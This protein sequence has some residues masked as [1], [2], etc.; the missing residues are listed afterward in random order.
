[1]LEARDRPASTVTRMI[2]RLL[3][4]DVDGIL[5]RTGEVGA[6]IFDEALV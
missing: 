4:W 5:L 1:M 6:A 3:L 2:R